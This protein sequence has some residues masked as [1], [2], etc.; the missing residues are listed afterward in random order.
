MKLR[1]RGFTLIE[2]WVVIAIIGVLAS[3]LLPSF[4]RAKERAKVTRCLSNLRQI[5]I[6]FSLYH[7]DYKERFP[8]FVVFETN[9]EPKFTECYMGGKDPLPEVQ[10]ASRVPSAGIRPLH[11]YVGAADVFHCPA[12]K[13]SA[14]VAT[15]QELN[16]TIWEM[17]GCN[18]IFNSI[19]R[20][21]TRLRPEDPE[22]GLHGKQTGWVP[23]PALYILM[24]ER[25]A[26][27]WMAR[28]DGVE[29]EMFNHTHYSNLQDGIHKRGDGLKFISPILFVDGHSAKHDFTRVI[30]RDPVFCNEPTKDWIW[31]KP[32]PEANAG[33]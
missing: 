19:P 20:T 30:D 18:Y 33:P 12:D 24:Y 23:H 31:Y 13:I 10:L 32:A 25:P 16:G 9:G 17:L 15:A 6:G 27:R 11:P 21:D 22:N 14:K 28:I 5:G 1:A 8:L 29:W 2:L 4:V 7:S 3:L 26:T